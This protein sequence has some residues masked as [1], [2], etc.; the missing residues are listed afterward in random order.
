MKLF[1]RVVDAVY[2][3]KAE[4]TLDVIVIHRPCVDIG[5]D[6]FDISLYRMCYRERRK[7]VSHNQRYPLHY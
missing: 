2:V 6:Y 1:V 7:F 5:L 4:L 3:M